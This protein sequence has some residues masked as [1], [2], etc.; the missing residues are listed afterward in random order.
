MKKTLSLILAV[1]LIAGLTCL[2]GCSNKFDVKMTDDRM[3]DDDTVIVTFKNSG[4]KTISHVEG[5]L[6]LFTGSSFNQTPTK[7]VHFEWNGTCK[8]GE[9]FKVTANVSGAPKGLADSVNRIGFYI[10]EIN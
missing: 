10:S 1:I 8:K 7:V 3:I 5:N 2:S 9:S 4:K 6:N